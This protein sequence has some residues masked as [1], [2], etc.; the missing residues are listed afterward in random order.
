MMKSQVEKAP[1][2]WLSEELLTSIAKFLEFKDILRLCLTSKDSSKALLQEFSTKAHP[3]AVAY[4]ARQIMQERINTPHPEWFKMIIRD[5]LHL[6]RYED[7]DEENSGAVVLFSSDTADDKKSLEIRTSYI[8][9]DAGFN[10]LEA[11]IEVKIT[12]SSESPMRKGTLSIKWEYNN[13][14]DAADTTTTT[15]S[16]VPYTNG[17]NPREALEWC[18]LEAPFGLG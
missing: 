2:M 12:P 11:F 10:T 15:N 3:H 9:S 4:I 13:N 14:T 8:S 16:I 6:I 18:P 1:S 7:L 17:F 5:P